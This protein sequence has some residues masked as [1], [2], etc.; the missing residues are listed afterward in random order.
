MPSWTYLVGSCLNRDVE[1]LV[2]CHRLHVL[3]GSKADLQRE[4]KEER[5]EEERR[6]EQVYVPDLPTYKEHD[7]LDTKLD[8][9]LFTNFSSSPGV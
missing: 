1:V 7:S 9:R 2:D 5:R 8:R 6:K 4:K 3:S